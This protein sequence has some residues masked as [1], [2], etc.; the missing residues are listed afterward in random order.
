MA[1][2][3]SARDL[4]LDHAERLIAEQG[5][6]VPLRRI[7]Q[8]A[9]Q[10][11]NAAIRYHF[12][13]R[14]QLIA[15]VIDRRQKELERERLALLAA[16]AGGRTDLRTLIETLLNP[17]F[18]L[19]RRESPSYHARF[20]EKIR[21]LPGIDFLGRHDWPATTLIIAQIDAASA[22]ATDAPRAHRVRGVITAVFAL[23]ADLERM[24]FVNDGDRR[25]AESMV[26][27]MTLALVAASGGEHEPDAQSR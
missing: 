21:D 20:M 9:Q 17:V 2:Q 19:Q 14:E 10:R 18:A 15:A 4:L 27:N 22:G 24:A 26:I 25:E 16:E 12:G 13:T 23:L 11:N 7:V 1:T 5:P 8:A 3:G 6:A